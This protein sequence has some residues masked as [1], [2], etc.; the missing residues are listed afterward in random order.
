MI[1][2][3]RLQI[4][5]LVHQKGTVTAAARAA[6]LTPSAVS[7][8]IR[9]LAREVGVDLLER[10]GRRVRLTDAAHTL[11]AHAD[12]LYAQWERARADLDAHARGAA[13]TVRMCGFATALASVVVPAVLRLAEARPG[14]AARMREAETGECFDLLLAGEAD[15]AV[16]APT[17][18]SPPVDDPR[19]EQFPLLEDPQD[20]LVAAGHRLAGRDSVALAEAAAEPWI[21]APESLDWHRMIVAACAAAGFAP[22][23]A[24]EAREWNAICALVAGG[25][26][27]CLLPRL[28]PLPAHHGLVRVP[29]RGDPAPTRRILACVRRGGARA[30][31]TAHGLAALREVARGLPPP[32]VPPC[33]DPG[34]DARTDLPPHRHRR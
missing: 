3:R 2:V 34:H 8:Q 25:F 19:F 24:H 14:V 17:A 12:V 1:D 29:L 30:A 26:G 15:I 7:Q 16:V 6:H 28:A 18:E 9:L 10:R 4:L 22:R 20:L 5:R 27:V 23:V 11:L 21:A 33:R 31:A 32:L 13:G